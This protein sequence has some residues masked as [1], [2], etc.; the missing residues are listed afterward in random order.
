MSQTS[1]LSIHMEKRT[2]A[3]EACFG[4]LCGAF[5][6]YVEMRSKK[7]SIVR[8]SIQ[9]HTISSRMHKK[10]L[11]CPDEVG[12]R[13]LSLEVERAYDVQPRGKAR[14]RSSTWGL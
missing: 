7:G 10:A 9:L 13:V 12:G 1:R 6:R 2:G 3:A 4:C 11:E 5:A 8:H 14:I